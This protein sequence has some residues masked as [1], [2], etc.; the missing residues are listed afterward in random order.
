MVRTMTHDLSKHITRLSVLFVAAILVPGSFLA[1][2]SIQNARSQK[3]LA[4][5]RL[6]EEEERLVEELSLY[7]QNE[8]LRVATQVF[9]VTDKV[10][11]N[12]QDAA[13]PS[14]VGSYVAQ[15]FALDNAGRF[16]WPKYAETD[17][18]GSV[19]AE[20]AQFPPAFSRAE[21]AEFAEKN[22][23]AA[24]RLYRTAQNAALH[25]AARAAAIN[26]LARVLAKS[27]Q[28]RQAEAQYEVLLERFGSTQDANGM[29]YARY[30]LH[31][32]KEISINDPEAISSQVSDVLSR[33][34]SGEMPLTGQTDPLLLE[35]EE[36]LDRNPGATSHSLMREKISL[37]RK[38]LLHVTQ[39]SRL[40]DLLQSG[41]SGASSPLALGAFEAVARIAAGSSSLFV[42]RRDSMRPEIVGFQVALEPLRSALLDQASQ[43]PTSPPMEVFIVPNGEVAASAE[44][45]ALVRDLSPYLPGWR[46]TVRTQDPGFVSGY[47]SRQHWIYG[48]T[49]TLLLAGMVLG[50]ML[51]LRDLS[52]ERRLSQL[53]TDFVTNV[54]HE[55]KTP[56]T[57]IRMFAETLRMRRTRNETEQLECLD[58]II[59]ETQRLSRLINTVL[60]FSRIERGQK[61]Y[62]M[63]EVNV[64]EVARSTLNTLKYPLE[65]QGFE[66]A[67]EMEPGVRALADADALEQAMLNLIDNAVKYSH[68]NKF[69]HIGLWTQD[70]RVFFR[71]T[72]KG[73]GIPETD[74]RRIFEKFYRA[75]VEKEQDAGGAGLGL[76]VVK[77]VVEAHQGKIE[78]ESKV[79][80]GSSFTITLP[81]IQ[82][83]APGGA[84]RNDHDPRD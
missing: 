30:A 20:S 12:L 19:T 5:K 34:V 41:V 24:A 64:S 61:E 74:Q 40:G 53:R 42:V 75:R 77:H 67:T 68:R 51:V 66:L 32:L 3:E 55:L 60:D 70:N 17:A 9:D 31:Q 83:G 50:V 59:G 38:R 33:L 25:D 14:D 81:G 56:L 84:A 29:S 21:K 26:G 6:L 82:K 69:V 27:G 49:L 72:D 37:L 63:T 44:H 57:S 52:R 18:A 54:T 2:F 76:T 22:L 23:G 15:V 45:A 7:F 39:Y 11:P 35:V 79:G 1:Y 48:T 13:L 78:V 65:E 10:Y 43:I 46:V 73:I 4:E 62:R 71:V 16:L 58:V 28:L 36:W 8:L 80:E 47:V